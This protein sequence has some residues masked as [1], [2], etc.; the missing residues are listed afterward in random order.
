MIPNKREP[1]SISDV[2]IMLKNTLILITEAAYY[3]VHML[4]WVMQ[5]KCHCC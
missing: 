5:F 2:L 1:P 3:T 4:N